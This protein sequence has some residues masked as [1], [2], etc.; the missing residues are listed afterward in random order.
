MTDLP[1]VSRKV[2][3]TVSC[4]LT[5]L[6][7]VFVSASVVSA[8]SKPTWIELRSPHF[9]LVSNAGEGK[10]RRTA[11]QFEM[12]RAVLR[13]YFGQQQDSSEQPVIILAAKDE[14]TL[15]AL[16]PQFWAQKGA[17]HPAGVY[18]SRSDADYIGIR[19][20]VSLDR[21]AYDPYEPVYHEYAH[22]VTRQ[23][24][25]A[26]PLWMVE[27]LAEFYG[28]IRIRNKEVFV[29]ASSTSNLIIPHH[30]APAA[31]VAGEHAIRY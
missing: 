18:L 7:V 24:I 9:I 22:Y 23:L 10:A 30:I 19:L 28:N 31:N 16:L 17:A 8:G 3:R 29:G 21:D 20:D 11:T 14:S 5:V 4:R 13:A 27:G 26:M 1:R 15:K 2:W 6:L 12:I 25:A